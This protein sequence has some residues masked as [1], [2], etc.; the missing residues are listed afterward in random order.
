M[1][2]HQYLGL[3]AK[4]AFTAVLALSFV[5]L[6]CPDPNGG[7]GLTP[8]YSISLSQSGTHTFP[9][10]APGYG[11]QTGKRVIITNTGNQATGALTMALSGTNGSSF[12]L[13]TTSI[14]SITVGRTGT[15]T[16]VPITG[17]AEGT[18]TAT[19]TVSGSNGIT[20]G[21]NVSF[22]VTPVPAYT[23]T[24][25]TNGGTGFSALTSYTYGI[26]ATL[27]TN[28]EKTGHTFSGWF[29]NEDL[30]G[31]AVTAITAT[32]TGNKEYWVKW[33][34]NSYAVTWKN[35]DG[36]TLKTDTVNYGTT[37]AY[38]DVTPT[39]AA[40]ANYTYSFTG[41]SPTIATVSADTTYTAQFVSHALSKVSTII[42]GGGPQAENLGN[43]E[44][45]A[46]SIDWSDGGSLTA[47]VATET[48]TWADGAAFVWYMD[49]TVL[50]GQTS[51]S[52]TISAQHYVPGTHT[53]AVK[54]TKGGD[55]YS[56][57]VIF[58][59]TQ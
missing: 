45:P 6:G 59:I 17:L 11:A 26:G 42:F 49:G 13:S 24:L 35:Y 28:G 21:F 8:T 9:A 51:D 20:A 16:V 31:T 53:L 48:D 25:N 1:K 47:T 32:D 5:F 3:P 36:T 23:I 44:N 39:K 4:V 56:K 7:G 19:V 18:Y 12:T 34:V 10:A 52:I 40:D 41:W 58:T 50:S 30:T 46:A 54:V 2:R 15:F 43:L 33:T 14:S 27:P 29:A 22:R 38:T 57:T 37:P 55:S